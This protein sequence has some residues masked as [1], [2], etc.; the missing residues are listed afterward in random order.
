VALFDS[1]TC[2]AFG[3]TFMDEEEAESF[4][5][6]LRPRD[7]REL[8]ESELTAAYSEWLRERTRDK[9]S[10]G[11][12]TGEMLWPGTAHQ[13]VKCKRCGEFLPC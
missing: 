6:W 4:I 8:S 10:S 13:G 2:W 1:V 7:A 9:C 3:P 5:T 11:H 12:D